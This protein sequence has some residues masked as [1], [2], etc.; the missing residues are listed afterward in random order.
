MSYPISNL[1]GNYGG[2]TQYARIAS[3][4][5][6]RRKDLGYRRAGAAVFSEGDNCIFVQHHAMSTPFAMITSDDAFTFLREPKTLGES[7]L[8]RQLTTRYTSFRSRKNVIN[9]CYIW[10]GR[11]RVPCGAGTVIKRS[12]VYNPVPLVRIRPTKEVNKAWKKL[13]GTVAP[14]VS[15]LVRLSEDDGA[16]PKQLSRS[17]LLTLLEDGNPD[18][19]AMIAWGRYTTQYNG[20]RANQVGPA[21]D[22]EYRKRVVSNTRRVFREEFYRAHNGYE[23]YEVQM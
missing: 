4:L 7:G 19:S 5:S 9:R 22:L 10:D 6:F 18:L 21:Y 12:G 15:A 8:V 14:A 16:N 3:F 13:Y 20:W 1:V 11:R 2:I 17:T 23:Q